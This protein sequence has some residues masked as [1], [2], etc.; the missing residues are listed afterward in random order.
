[1]VILGGVPIRKN[2]PDENIDL[3]LINLSDLCFIKKAF[4]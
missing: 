3:Y 1:M 4:S 2:L